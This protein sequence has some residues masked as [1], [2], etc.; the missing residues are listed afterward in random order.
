MYRLI[1]SVLAVRLLPLKRPFAKL[2]ISAHLLELIHDR[3]RNS[4]SIP[5]TLE[6]RKRSKMHRT[7]RSALA[8]YL[9]VPVAVATALLLRL[10]LWPE[11]QY[12][13]PFLLLWP[14]VMFCAWYGGLGPGLL[15]TMVSAFAAYR[16]L[17][18]PSHAFSR[19]D[20]NGILGTGLF[21]L[22]GFCISLLSHRLRLA[23]LRI[24]ED[25][26][27]IFSQ[28]EWLR[29][30]LGSIGD[31]VIATDR[32]G[33][34]TFLNSVAE[35]LTGWSQKEATGQPMEK[36][37]PIVNE[38]TR[39][40]VVNPVRKVLK[41]QEVVSLANHTVLIAKDGNERPIDDSAAPIRGDDENTL[42][43][44]LVFRDVSERRRLENEIQKRMRDLAE[45]DRHKNQFL[46]MLGHELRNPLAPARIALALLRQ[47]RPENPRFGWARE[48]LERQVQ[49]IARLVDDLLDLSRISTGKIRL[50]KEAVE[51]HDV[52]ERAVEISRP[53]ME[54]RKQELSESLPPQPV[55]LDGD[56]TRLAQVVS[57]LLNNAAKYTPEG[58]HIWLTAAQEADAVVIQV[59]DNGIGIAPQMLPH[60][61]DLFAQADCSLERSQG[62]LGLGLT[63]VRKLVE[64]HGGSIRASSSGLGRGSEFEVRLRALQQAP[65]PPAPSGA[66]EPVSVCSGRR[67]LVVDDNRDAAETLGVLLRTWDLDV[68]L[69]YD[70]PSALKSADSFQPEVI[71]LDIGLPGMDGYEVARQVR[72]RPGLERPLLIALT[73]YGQESDRRR[74]HEAG[75]DRH[76][77]KPVDPEQLMALVTCP[78]PA[79]ACSQGE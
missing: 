22:L 2:G 37:F 24:E 71:L 28:R 30:T 50:Q 49:Q 69:A 33:N 8:R 65:A 41:T 18:E 4:V 54:A 51:V 46:A 44:V 59:R 19:T 73:G 70:G 61:F 9:A 1:V 23:K 35:S 31:G 58:G 27:E 14:A 13:L 78:E 15:A 53:L 75:F 74:S 45:A 34:I 39:A 77:V 43:V 10:V 32:D 17:I 67:V 76:I 52:L 72:R 11:M 12:E 3:K 38:S 29:V 26:Q 36:V 79:Q 6:R 56:A 40:S 55:W 25:A 20:P 68:R 63:L 21:V 66:P 7:S 60:I 48:V 62:G 64:L 16:F 42:G 5:L 57:N 47:V